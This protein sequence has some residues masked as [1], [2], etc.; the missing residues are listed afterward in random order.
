MILVG[1]EDTEASL[2]SEVDHVGFPCNTVVCNQFCDLVFN[3]SFLSEPIKYYES[4][5]GKQGGKIL[6]II[7]E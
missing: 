6:K 3:D 7:F 5:F 2:I 4:T 1:C